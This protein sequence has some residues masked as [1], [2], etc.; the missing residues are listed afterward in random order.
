MLPNPVPVSVPITLEFLQDLIFSLLSNV[1]WY[2][3]YHIYLFFFLLQC[4][5]FLVFPGVSC[6][7]QIPDGCRSSFP[8]LPTYS[9]LVTSS[10]PILER[11]SLCTWPSSLYLQLWPLIKSRLIYPALN[12][13]FPVG[14]PGGS[15]NRYLHG[16][17]L[18]LLQ[19][20]CPVPLSVKTSQI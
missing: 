7:P 19:A 16:S 4:C 17:L 10:G 2:L 6:S 11:P 9:S 12:L 20:S 18:Y 3:W 8:S 5:C 14:C 15:S 1:F 13:T